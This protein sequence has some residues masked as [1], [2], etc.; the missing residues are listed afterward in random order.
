[1]TLE[2]LYKI[3][4]AYNLK[5]RNDFY[6]V[7]KIDSQYVIFSKKNMYLNY[8]FW[9]RIQYNQILSTGIFSVI[10]NNL[11]SCFMPLVIDELQNSYNPATLLSP[12]SRSRPKAVCNALTAFSS[13]SS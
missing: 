6:S 2:E 1:M 4:Y 9:I 3:A 10:I 7:E 13:C 12:S 8:S 5:Q 11:E